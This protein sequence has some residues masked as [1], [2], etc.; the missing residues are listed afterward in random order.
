MGGEEE[1]SG[2]G[3]EGGTRGIE[4]GE[5][6]VERSGGAAKEGR[7]D[8]ASGAIRVRLGDEDG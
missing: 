8:W 7:A 4:L 5:G 3:K 6:A 2:A 1:W